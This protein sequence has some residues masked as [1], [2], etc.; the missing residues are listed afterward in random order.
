M[1]TLKQNLSRV[2][3]QGLSEDVLWSWAGEGLMFWELS[4]SWQLKADGDAA[5]WNGLPR[6]SPSHPMSYL[7]IVLH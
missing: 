5:K 2:L 1:L 6:P 7:F 3:L 4:Q